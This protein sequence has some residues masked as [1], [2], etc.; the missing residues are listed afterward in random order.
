VIPTLGFV[1][2]LLLAFLLPLSSVLV[3]TVVVAIGVA[4]F[5]VR[6]NLAAG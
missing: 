1:G 6:P 5:A 3:G 2:C 4:A